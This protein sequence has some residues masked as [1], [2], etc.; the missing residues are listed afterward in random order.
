M[1]A[2]L[3]EKHNKN[4]ATATIG[5]VNGKFIKIEDSYNFNGRRKS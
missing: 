3:V 1:P 5:L 4:A 2:E